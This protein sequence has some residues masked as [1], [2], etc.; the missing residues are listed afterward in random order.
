MAEALD[1]ALNELDDDDQLWAGILT[2]T[3]DVLQCRERPDG[4]R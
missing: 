4:G 3:G 2:G 1:A